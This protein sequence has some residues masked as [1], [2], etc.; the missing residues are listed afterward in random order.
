[1]PDLSTLSIAVLAWIA[2]VMLLAGFAHGVIGFGFPL[3][4][5]PLLALA[6]DFKAAIVISLVPTIGVTLVNAFR[7]GRLR[8]SIGRYWFLPPCLA[9]GAWLGTHLLIVA[10]SEPFL[11]VLAALVAVFLNL[12]RFGRTEIAVV[13]R[14]PTPFAV[15]FGLL[16]GVSEATA[17]V[18]GPPLLVYFLLVGLHP[19][20]LVQVLNF[21]FIAGKAAQIGTW[22]AV[23]GVGLVQWLVLV[24]FAFVALLT[25]SIGH[26]LHDR[27]DAATYAKWLRAYLWVMV[28]LLVAQFLRSVA[29]R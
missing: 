13:K 2:L 1:M 23:G 26:R 7:G 11:L 9:A 4:A 12:E 28:V 20:P 14:H 24:P 21:S 3:V 25:L 27:V 8:E 5:T 6:M 18:A 22:S 17:N 29:V 16:A 10:P 15:A 19:R